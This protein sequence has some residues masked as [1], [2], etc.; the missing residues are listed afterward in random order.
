MSGKWRWTFGFGV[1]GAVLAFLFQ[2]SRN[3]IGTTLLRSF[4]A[5]L[6]FA[7]L[8]A[9]VRIALSVLLKPAAPSYMKLPKEGNGQAIDLTTPDDGGELTDM[10]KEQRTDGGGRPISG[11][12]PLNPKRLVTLEHPSTEDVVTAV[13]RMT[14]E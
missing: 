2:V 8:A 5:F 14:D 6:A 1:F 7:A 4:Y 11:F 9:V 10:L 12:Q 3:T 13:R